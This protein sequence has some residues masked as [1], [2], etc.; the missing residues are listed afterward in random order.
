MNSLHSICVFCGSSSGANSVY[1]DAAVR[2]GQEM[3]QR[4][5]GLVYGGGSVGLMGAIAQTVHNSGAP[6]K[7]IIP[8]ALQPRE[9]AGETIGEL[10]VVESMHERKL[11]M[12]RYSDA[13]I[14]MPGGFGTMDELFEVVT[15]GQLGIQRKAIG[16]LNVNGY[17]DPILAWIERAMHE[18]FIR[19]H[20]RGLIVVANDPGELLD[21][22][23][24][25]EP[26]A[27]LTQWLAWDQT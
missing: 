15:W 10:H 17:W 26:P 2:L 1:A 9:L 19:P 21:I 16:L 8:R 11:L 24:E 27:G 6:V 5:I 14:A 4:Q 22:L 12:A 25:H 23:A 20:H 3:A 7:G 18:S 13:F